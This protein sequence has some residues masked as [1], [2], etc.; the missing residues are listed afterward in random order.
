MEKKLL[1][2]FSEKSITPDRP[3]SLAGQ[4]HTR[5]SEYVETPVMVNVMAVETAD[6]CMILCSCDLGGVSAALVRKVRARIAERCADIDTDKIIIS[7][8]HT[9]TSLSYGAP[10]DST[11]PAA[12]SC[13]NAN[14]VMPNGKRFVNNTVIGEEVLHGAEATEFL[15]DRISDAIVEAWGARQPA[16]CSLGFGRASIGYCRRVIRGHGVH[17]LGYEIKEESVFKEVEGGS[18]TGIEMIFVNDSES[19]P[20]GV[21]LSVACPSQIVE[22]KYFVS[23]DYWGKARNYLKEHFGEDF[24]IIGLC[25]A[26]GDQSPRDTLRFL[27]GIEPSMTDVEGTVSVGKDLSCAVI[28]AYERA[29][30]GFVPKIDLIHKTVMLDMPINKLTEEEYNEAKAR[31]YAYVEEADKDV[32]D[33]K[34]MVRIHPEVGK[35]FLYEWQKNFD[36]LPA[37]IHVVRFGDMAIATNPFELFLDYGNQIKVRSK[38]R[39]TMLIQLA[40]DRMG[41]LP[42]RKAEPNGGYGTSIVSCYCGHEGGE[43]LVEKTLEIINSMWD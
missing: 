7:A 14:T 15:A 31:L 40:M 12:T 42:T 24:H 32:F 6:D 37:E 11:R 9:H 2:G 39:Q 33:F 35:V 10:E 21:A 28:N 3:I 38:A 34:D 29:K 22:N 36:T 26:A 4:F 41:Y 19:K 1:I 20:I 43:F 30:G 5:I 13:A 27:R 25:S 18:D 16:L 8:T 23:S 17:K